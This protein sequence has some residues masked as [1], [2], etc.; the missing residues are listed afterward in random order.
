MAPDERIPHPQEHGDRG[1]H[2]H[3]PGGAGR[4]LAQGCCG[5]RWGRVGVFTLS[6]E[7][8]G[9]ESPPASEWEP[10]RRPHYTARPWQPLRDTTDGTEGHTS[11]RAGSEIHFQE[12]VFHGTDSFLHHLTGIY[13][14]HQSETA[15]SNFSYCGMTS[16]LTSHSRGSALRWGLAWGMCTSGSPCAACSRSW[17]AGVLPWGSLGGVRGPHLE[18]TVP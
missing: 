1:G 18:G 6:Q 3:K 17:R 7:L 2:P 10:L 15:N 13:N 4:G 11:Y 9:P 16:P 5:R 14:C 8:V 12:F